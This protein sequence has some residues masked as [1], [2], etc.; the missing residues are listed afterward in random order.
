VKKAYHFYLGCKISDQDKSG[1]PHICCRKCATNLS[2]CLNGKRHAMPFAVPMVW[3][4]PSNHTTD[5]YF[6]MVP[7]VLGGIAKKKRGA[8]VY[9]NIP[10]ALRP[11]LCG[12]GISVPASPKEFTI[13]SDEED[14]GESTSGSPETPASTEPHVSHGRSSAPQP[15][16]LTQ[17]EMND[18]VHDLEL[19]KSKAEVLGSKLKQWYM[20]LHSATM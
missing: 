9:P 3:R 5:C 11:V 8:I 18:L 6:Y 17:N 1:A 20:T 12:E 14:E 7:P 4:E 13:D 15:H 16:I 2:Q 19:S 10:S